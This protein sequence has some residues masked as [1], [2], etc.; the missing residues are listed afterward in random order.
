MKNF[1]SKIAVAV[2]SLTAV[3]GADAASLK[4]DRVEPPYWW[5]GMAQ[6]TLQIMLHGHDIAG[7]TASLNYPGVNIA[8]QVR[9]DSPNYLLLYLTIGKDAAPGTLDIRLKEGKRSATLPL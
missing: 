7:A 1:F 2:A 9:L 8:E 4:I 6:D 3:A 5:T